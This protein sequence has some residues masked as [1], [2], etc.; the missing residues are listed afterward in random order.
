M[1]LTE[2][3]LRS[4]IREE[5]QRLTERGENLHG[6]ESYDVHE[7]GREVKELLQR[8]TGRQATYEPDN[9]ETITNAG[10]DMTGN[11]IITFEGRTQNLYIS[12]EAIRGGVSGHIRT[13]EGELLRSFDTG[14][15]TPKAVVGRMTAALRDVGEL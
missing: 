8:K 5:L 13:A 11:S 7:F 10:I 3:K 2:S 14:Q 4:I 6:L 9:R 1:K 12:L 15:Q